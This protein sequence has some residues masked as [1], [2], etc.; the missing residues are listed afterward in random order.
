MGAA[1]YKKIMEADGYV[2]L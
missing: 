1:R 2:K